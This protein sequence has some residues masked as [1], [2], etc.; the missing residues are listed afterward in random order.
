M[1]HFLYMIADEYTTHGPPDFFTTIMQMESDFQW[2][3]LL[4]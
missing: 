4:R 1:L 3:D 2:T